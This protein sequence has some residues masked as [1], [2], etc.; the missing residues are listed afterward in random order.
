VHYKI[1]LKYVWLCIIYEN[2]ERYQ[3]DVTIVIYH[4]KYLYMFQAYK[5]P[6]RDIYDNKS[7]LLHQGGTSRQNYTALK[8]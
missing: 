5:C 4:H 8:F 7:Q 3:L 2:D 6:K 1:L